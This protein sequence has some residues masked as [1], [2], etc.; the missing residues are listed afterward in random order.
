MPVVRVNALAVPR[1]V[2][3][4][5]TPPMPRPPPCERC[6]RTTPTSASTTV[7]CRT[8]RTVSIKQSGRFQEMAGAPALKCGQIHAFHGISKP[9]HRI[10][11]SD[12]KIQPNQAPSRNLPCGSD[13]APPSWASVGN[14]SPAHLLRPRNIYWKGTA[15]S[16][17]HRL[18]PLLR[19]ARI[20]GRIDIFDAPGAVRGHLHY[21]LVIEKD[22][23]RRG[24]REREEA[25]RRQCLCGAPIGLL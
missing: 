14:A 3:N 13:W 8:M 24:G 10:W 16:E 23:M 5:G 17:R 20:V 4:P 21:R 6:S 19:L 9:A 12:A 7:R 22:E 2:I 11:A 15:V 18:P 1:G 25:S